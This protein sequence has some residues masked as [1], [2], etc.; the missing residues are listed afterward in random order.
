MTRLNNEALKTTTVN[1]I[2]DTKF[3]TDLERQVVNNIIKSEYMDAT[4][5]DMVNFPVWSFSA[6]N[7]TKQLSGALGSLVKKGL[8]ICDGDGGEETC[9]LTVDGVAWAKNNGLA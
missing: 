4:G 8:V 7:S 9:S 1:T 3:V 2:E 6:T 5:D